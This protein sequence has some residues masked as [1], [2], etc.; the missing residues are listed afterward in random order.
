[1]TNY[2]TK[3]C[4]NCREK[5]PKKWFDGKYN[6]HCKKWKWAERVIQGAVRRNLDDNEIR[7]DNGEVPL[8]L[9]ITTRDLVKLWDKQ[10]GQCHYTD[11]ELICPWLD[12]VKD[13]KYAP[14]LDRINNERGYEID[15]VA[16][17]I[18][19]IN[20]KKKHKSMED[21]YEC[22]ADDAYIFLRTLSKIS[23]NYL[24]L[25]FDPSDYLE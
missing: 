24:T 14:S 25:K 21:F 8:P 20:S 1:M 18:H 6:H 3:Y 16:F 17:A 10:R 22:L 4:S 12:P 15:N 2:D 9:T 5:H 23:S 11:M 13:K 7:K 19:T